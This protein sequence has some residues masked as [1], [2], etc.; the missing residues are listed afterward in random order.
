VQS[1]WQD[2]FVA[3]ITV[4]NNGSTPISSWRVTWTWGGNQKVTN[5]WSTTLSQS[6][7]SVTAANASYNG[8]LAPG[9]SASFGFQGTYSGTNSAPTLA[10]SGS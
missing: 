9:Q 4:T 5:S 7:T 3:A 6:G 2:G 8:S 10:V 1:Q